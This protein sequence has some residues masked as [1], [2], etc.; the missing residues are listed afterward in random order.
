MRGLEIGPGK[1]RVQGFETYNLGDD[2][3]SDGGKSDHVGD[4]RRLS[5]FENNTF[6]CVYSSHCIEHVHWYQVQETI[7]EWTRVI[8]PGGTLEVWTVNGLDVMNE[9]IHYENTGQTTKKLKINWRK[10][11][12]KQDP[13]LWLVGK[14]YNYTINP[15]DDF[16][17]Q[18]HRALL[19]PN[20][21]MKCFRQAGLK[22]VKRMSMDENRLRNRHGWINMG[23]IGTK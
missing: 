5:K 12:T 19:T 1:M 15:E 3:K 10:E 6:D 17:Y 14:L 8:K 13:Y 20:F 11:L 2:Q 9:I 4:A 7:T 22:N 21:L 16:D 18:L 23:I